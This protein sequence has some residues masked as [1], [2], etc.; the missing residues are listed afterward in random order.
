MP[1][2]L[3]S[4]EWEHV[5]NE[6]MRVKIP[7]GWLAVTTT[8]LLVGGKDWYSKSDMVLVPDPFYDWQIVTK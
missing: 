6:L 4:G 8:R 2:H 3:F 5:N 7:G 1:E